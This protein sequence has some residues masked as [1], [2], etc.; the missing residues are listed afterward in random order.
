MKDRI[1]PLQD[2]FRPPIHPRRSWESLHAMWSACMT[3]DL[4]ARLPAGYYAD[5]QTH[6]GRIEID[7]A[8]YEEQAPPAPT[9][10]AGG[11]AVAMAVQPRVWTPPAPTHIIPLHFPETYEVRVLDSQ[12]GDLLVAAIELVS[13]GNKDRPAERQ[14]FVAKCSGLLSQGVSLIIV[15]IVTN[16]HANLHHELLK[17]MEAPAETYAEKADLYAVAYRPVVR[18]EQEQLEI[19]PEALSLG[20]SLPTLPLRLSADIFTNVCLEPTYTEACRRLRLLCH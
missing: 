12:R 10:E 20:G 18:G 5:V 2:H 15:D 19:W 14:A 17:L 1:M 4:N 13:P 8:T 3:E 9:D 16:L 7:V 6:N 11:P